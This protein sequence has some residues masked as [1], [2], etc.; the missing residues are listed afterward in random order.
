[1]RLTYETHPEFIRLTLISLS[2]LKRGIRLSDL[3]V[4]LTSYLLMNEIVSIQMGH[5]LVK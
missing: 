4:I 3:G 2:P 1:M 5:Y